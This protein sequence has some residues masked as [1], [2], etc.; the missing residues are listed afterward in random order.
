MNMIRKNGGFTLVELIVVIAILAILAGVAVPAYSG[1][2]KSA[3]EAA[4]I[5]AM[6]AVKTAAMATYATD[7][8]V[9]KIEVEDKGAT[10]DTI[11]VYVDGTAVTGTATDEDFMTF[12]NIPTNGAFNITLKSGNKATWPSADGDWEISGTAVSNNAG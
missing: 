4:D 8:A 1:Y 9:T 12:M 2:I 5:T 7:G 10:G 6:A 3:N 11:T